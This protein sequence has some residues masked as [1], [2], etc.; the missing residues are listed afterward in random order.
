MSSQ[1]LIR[2]GAILSCI[3]TALLITFVG[4]LIAFPVLK[5]CQ[6]MHKKCEYISKA[7]LPL[8]SLI[9]PFFL[10]GSL[11]TIALGVG[12]IRFGTWYQCKKTNDKK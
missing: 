5:E 6:N 4:I 8:K 1:T 2:S 9:N 11:F 3:G 10:S 7:P 12:F